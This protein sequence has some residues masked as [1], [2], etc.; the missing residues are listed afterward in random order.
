LTMSAAMTTGLIHAC[1]LDGKGG[2]RILSWDEVQSWSA[3]MGRLW[4]HFDYTDELARDWILNNSELDPLVADA[5]ITDET[6]PRATGIG[7]GLLIALRGVN[8]NP[9]SDPDDM[10][11]VRLWVDNERIISTRKRKLLSIYDILSQLEKGKGPESS[12]E[13]II[14]LADRLVWRMS[15]TVDMLEDEIDELEGRVLSDSSSSVRFDLAALRKQ[16]IM[17]RRYLSPQRDALARLMIEKVSWIDDTHRMKLREVSDR[18]IRHIENIDAVRERAAITQEELI[19]RVSEQLNKR[20][21]VLSVVAAIF[22]PLGFFTGLLGVN[23]GGIPGG[24]NPKAFLV[25]ILLLIVVVI[26]QVLLFRWK[27]WL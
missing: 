7:E 19:S 11:A 8:L 4:L 2:G 23:V 21:Y 17:L 25:F 12:A 16:T 24:D 14:D 27:K 3:S 6:R 13:F 18:L 22:L 26:F 20:M 9:G 1:L 10:V 15:D 5:L